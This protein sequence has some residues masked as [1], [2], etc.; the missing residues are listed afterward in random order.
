ML[1]KGKNN[2]IEKAFKR[3]FNSIK[4]L[5]ENIYEWMVIIYSCIFSLTNIFLNGSNFYLHILTYTYMDYSN[6]LPSIIFT[7]NLLKIFPNKENEIY[8]IL[9]L[10]FS[11][12]IK[13]RLEGTPL[14]NFLFL[15]YIRTVNILLTTYRK[16]TVDLVLF[17]YW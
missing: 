7:N 10:S 3:T 1:S 12:I 11:H 2:A 8:W 16:H 14:S 6:K 13:E 17:Y 4:E 9:Y 15:S 5:C